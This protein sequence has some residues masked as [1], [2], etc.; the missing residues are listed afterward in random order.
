[1][2]DGA[3]ANADDGDLVDGAM[4]DANNNV[5]QIMEEFCCITWPSQAIL[6]N[7]P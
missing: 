4:A 5:L 6:C 2:F 7:C 1:M 3:M